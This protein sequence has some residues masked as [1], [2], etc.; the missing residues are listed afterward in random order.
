MASCVCQLVNQRPRVLTYVVLVIY[1]AVLWLMVMGGSRIYNYL[2]LL[3]IW[4]LWENSAYFCLYVNRLFRKLPE[5]STKAREMLPT[6]IVRRNAVKFFPFI[7]L[8]RKIRVSS[9]HFSSLL[10]V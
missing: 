2:F 10:Q 4:P 3:H 1:L 6:Y 8:V 9:V 5:I 7:F